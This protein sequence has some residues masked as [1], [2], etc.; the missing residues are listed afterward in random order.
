LPPPPPQKTNLT[1]LLLSASSA[2]FALLGGMGV[3]VQILKGDNFWEMLLEL[4]VH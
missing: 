4:A 1:A 3:M 2:S